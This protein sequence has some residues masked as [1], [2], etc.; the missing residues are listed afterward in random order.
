MA[1]AVVSLVHRSPVGWTPI[2]KAALL[3]SIPTLIRSMSLL[4]G[5]APPDLMRVRARDPINCSGSTA[6]NA[7]EAQT[8]LR[9]S[10]PEGLRAPLPRRVVSDREDIRRPGDSSDQTG[11]QKIRRSGGSQASF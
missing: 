4:L 10:G 6:P 3:T 2:T 7:E 1:A 8:N 9:S 11:G 5:V